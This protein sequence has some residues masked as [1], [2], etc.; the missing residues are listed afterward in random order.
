MLLNYVNEFRQRG[1]SLQEA[2]ELAISHCIDEGILKGFLT[3]YGME[4]KGML[5]DDITIEEFAEIRAAEK[6]EEG[7]KEGEK[8]GLEK[9]R[10]ETKEK[11]NRL[12]QILISE[13]RIDDLEKASKDEDFQEKLFQ[14]FS[15]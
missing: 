12:I 10:A 3:R 8:E 9:G 1:Q 2:V 5:L 6:W 13:G 11:M 14:E 7:R 4:V 15:L